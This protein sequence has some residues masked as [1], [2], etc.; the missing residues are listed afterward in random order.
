MIEIQGINRVLVVRKEDI[1]CIAHNH[2][3]EAKINNKF[4][5]DEDII[6]N[7]CYVKLDFAST[8][9]PIS[10]TEYERLKIILLEK[11]E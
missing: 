7:D 9:E 11:G 8:I 6:N 3:I 10:E 5:E 2:Y 1:E 4:G